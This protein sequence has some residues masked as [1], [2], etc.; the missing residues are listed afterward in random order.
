MF[1]LR[2]VN[3]CY[4]SMIP[5]RMQAGHLSEQELAHVMQTL[6]SNS[7]KKL[8]KDIIHSNISICFETSSSYRVVIVF[9]QLFINFLHHQSKI[10][11]VSSRPTCIGHPDILFKA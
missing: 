4:L 5:Y 9:Y 1:F 11:T 2:R 10:S 3:C 8:E 6:V 7:S